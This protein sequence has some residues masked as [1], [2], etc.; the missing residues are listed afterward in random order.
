MHEFC[1]I[2]ILKNGKLCTQTAHICAPDRAVI[3]DSFQK[4]KHAIKQ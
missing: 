4:G 1:Q 2:F 3:S